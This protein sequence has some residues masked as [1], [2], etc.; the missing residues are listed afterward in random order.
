MTKKEYLA[1]ILWQLES[2]RSLAP[3]L[4]ILVEHGELWDDVLDTLVV[5][6]E[7][8]IQSAS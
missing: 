7:S 3:W 5:A 2:I 1:Q 8:G 4:K 6:I